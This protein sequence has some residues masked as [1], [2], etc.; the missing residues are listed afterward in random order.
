[1]EALVCENISKAFKK[2][3]RAKTNGDLSLPERLKNRMSWERNYKALPLLYQKRL[4]CIG[5]I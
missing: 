5:P 1:M 3:Q 4:V 2:W